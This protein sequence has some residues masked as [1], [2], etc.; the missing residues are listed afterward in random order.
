MSWSLQDIWVSVHFTHSHV[1]ACTH[2]HTHKCTHTHAHKDTAYLAYLLFRHE[3]RD[4]N[5]QSCVVVSEF[6]VWLWWDIV[7][8]NNIDY[9]ALHSSDMFKIK[10]LTDTYRRLSPITH[11]VSIGFLRAWVYACEKV[12]D[13][14]IVITPCSRLIRGRVQNS[15]SYWNTYWQVR[16]VV[17]LKYNNNLFMNHQL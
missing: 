9:G 16:S 13:W 17:A 12:Q 11:V 15:S 2:A 6:F 8:A 4:S 1:H 7:S 5:R 14:N 10:I 3:G